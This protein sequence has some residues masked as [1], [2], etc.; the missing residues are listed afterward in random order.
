LKDAE[1]VQRQ[2]LTGSEAIRIQGL[3]IGTIHVLVS[4]RKLIGMRRNPETGALSRVFAEGGSNGDILTTPELMLVS[5]P[6]PDPRYVEHGPLTVET[7]FPLGS[8]VVVLRD[9]AR[10]CVGKI[11]GYG[12]PDHKSL[13]VQADVV[14]MEPPFGHSIVSAISDTYY[15]SRRTCEGLRISSSVLGRITGSVIV[16]PG[17]YDLGLNFKVRK[18]LFLPGYV[19]S[20]SSDQS[21]PVWAG[22]SQVREMLS[23]SSDQVVNN[24]PWEFTERAMHL[25]A[26]YQRQFPFV[27]ALLE[28]FSD[29]ASLDVKAFPGGKD[30]VIKIATWLQQLD[31]YKRPL[32]P[33]TSKFMAPAAIKA[34]ERAAD[35]YYSQLAKRAGSERGIYST[36]RL[37]SIHPADVYL[38]EANAYAVG[39]IGEG[40]GNSLG[41]NVDGLKS[42]PVLGDRVVNLSFQQAALGLRGTVVVVHPQSGFVEV[43]FDME[44]IGGST[45]GDLCSNGRGAL[46]PWSSVL[47]I[48]KT[49]PKVAA[50]PPPPTTTVAPAQRPPEQK[51]REI[52]AKPVA[53]AVPSTNPAVL[54]AVEKPAAAPVATKVVISPPNKTP[55]QVVKN[56]DSSDSAKAA[57]VNSTP[58]APSVA[59]LFNKATTATVQAPAP[60]PALVLAPA[61]PAAAV[62]IVKHTSEALAAPVIAP[63]VVTVVSPKP[64]TASPSNAGEKKTVLLTPS[65]VLRKKA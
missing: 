45:L 56:V 52:M 29:S 34:V 3:Q 22:S 59:K 44:F 40:S 35:A 58:L 46:I 57:E 54:K 26:A 21:G 55:L 32:V 24:G 17:S 11:V 5:A 60:T 9:Q 64:K 12:T 39:L 13:Q 8:S 61:P 27:F 50:R 63:R 48:S 2:L 36:V 30:T 4:V 65:A 14:P 18:T 16:M 49:Q 6:N 31:T 41:A 1:R 10:G 42:I 38:R 20:K 19:R 62:T 37:N 51:P 15:D 43:V 53:V 7:R 47:C 23:R 25:I 28:T 33:I